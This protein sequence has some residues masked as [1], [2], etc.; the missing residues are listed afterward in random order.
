MAAN[1]APFT[2]HWLAPAD[3]VA[4]YW[5]NASKDAGDHQPSEG[6]VHR[7]L[8]AALAMLTVP[9]LAAAQGDAGSGY[10][11]VVNQPPDVVATAAQ[12]AY[13]NLGLP[14]SGTQADG[15]AVVALNVP[16]N[17][18]IIH[19]PEEQF[20]DCGG[21]A[22]GISSRAPTDH[23]VSVLSRVN[24]VNGQTVVTVWARM[25]KRDVNMPPEAADG[26]MIDNQH[27][28]TPSA[29]GTTSAADINQSWC[30]G[31]CQ[32]SGRLEKRIAQAI[33]DAAKS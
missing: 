9:S 31:D 27:Q 5:K 6:V 33:A 16:V 25:T 8:L 1:I 14:V 12:V 18:T 7:I 26:R 20:F 10:S 22:T 24:V 28:Y 23:R 2:G 4:R 15:H 13:T 30:A 21:G 19:R 3:A 32:S 11:L 17:H 29:S